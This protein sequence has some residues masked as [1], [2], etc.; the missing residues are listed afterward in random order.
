[1]KKENI[2]KTAKVENLNEKI[3]ELLHRSQRLET[4]EAM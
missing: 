4:I 1:M 2:E 3:S